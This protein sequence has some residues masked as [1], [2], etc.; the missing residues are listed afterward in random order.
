MKTMMGIYAAVHVVGHTI[1]VRKQLKTK[2]ACKPFL[3]TQ[4]TPAGNMGYN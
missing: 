1:L 4:G 3:L 2:T